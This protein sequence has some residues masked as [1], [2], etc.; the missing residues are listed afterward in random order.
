MSALGLFDAK[1]CLS[2]R[3]DF[4]G[5]FLRPHIS[6]HISILNDSFH[7]KKL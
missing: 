3:S 6:Q 4:S 5:F 7:S 2:S 1:S